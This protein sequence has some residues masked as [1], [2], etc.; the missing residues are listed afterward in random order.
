V[1]LL[2]PNVDYTDK[3]FDALRVRLYKLISSAFPTWTEQNVANFGNILVELFCHVGD[4]LSYYQDS[5]AAEAF[6]VTA[7]Q[8]SSLLNLCKLLGFVAPGATPATVDGMFSIPAV[9]PSA[10]PIP[11]G[12]VVATPNI[13]GSVAF[14]T[15]AAATIPAGQLSVTTSLENSANAQDTF[16]TDG[17]PS[18]EVVLTHTPYLDGSAQVT[19]ASNVYVA[20]TNFLDSKAGDMHFVVVVDANDRARIR[21]GNGT[22]GFAPSGAC[23]VVYKT[24]GGSAGNVEA[25]SLTQVSGTFTTL[26]GVPITVACTNPLKAAGGNVRASNTSI[27]QLA[28]ASIRAPINSIAYEDFA[29]NVLKLP[30]IARALFLT[31]EQD[32][33]IAINTGQLFIIPQGGGTPSG[34]L[35]AAAVAQV[36][37]VYPCPTTFKVAAYAAQYKTVDVSVVANKRA[38]FTSAQLRDDVRSALAAYFAITNPDGSNNSNVNFGADYTDYAGSPSPILAWSDIFDV[39]RDLPSVR[40]IDPGPVGFLLN[41]IAGDVLLALKD[42]PALGV[43]TVVDGDTGLVVP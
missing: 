17:S 39:V 34:A 12:T 23:T 13:A 28:P 21:F 37:T 1:A 7:T 16:T 26:L 35:L 5:Q 38:G 18:Q 42:F 9:Q 33:G 30:S 4:V 24:G 29:I 27:K 43:V 41:G 11:V 6:I 22:N 8:R 32:P 25:G 20:R 15:L 14:Q 10:V 2:P 31:N 19:V 36:T 3:D 40:R